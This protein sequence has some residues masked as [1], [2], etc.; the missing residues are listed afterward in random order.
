MIPSS[1]VVLN[2]LPTNNNG[3]IDR[4]ALPK[5]PP[6]VANGLHE[7]V[8]PSCDIEIKIYQIMREVLKVDAFSV[9][10][11]IYDLGMNSLLA[12]RFIFQ[13]NTQQFDHKL[14]WGQ[15]FSTTSV[16]EIYQLIDKHASIDDKNKVL[17]P[18][19]Q[20]ALLGLTEI[21]KSVVPNIVQ[22]AHPP[23]NILLTGASGFVGIFILASIHQQIPCDVICL[24]RATSV[25]QVRCKLQCNFLSSN[26][27]FSSLCFK[28]DPGSEKIARAGR[29]IQD[30]LH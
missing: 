16:R 28:Y 24:V 25:E 10:A 22:F 11:N 30:I 13:F 27:F 12:A 9:T 4:K 20:D 29:S 2:S 18:W 1:W 21:S 23:S 3:K 5:P 17:N 6:N 26:N 15:F 7:F 14:T 19:Q 8:E